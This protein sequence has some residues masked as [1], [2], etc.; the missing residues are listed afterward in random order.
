[1]NLTYDDALSGFAFNFNL[2]RYDVAGNLC[3]E[4]N[5]FMTVDVT[6]AGPAGYCMPRLETHSGTTSPS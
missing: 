3:T 4:L 5:T 6:P 2:R 1:L